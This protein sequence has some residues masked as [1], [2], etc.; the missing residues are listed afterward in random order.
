[1]ERGA[2]KKEETLGVK[3]MVGTEIMIAIPQLIV[4]ELNILN[5]SSKYLRAKA[6][7]KI[8]NK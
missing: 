6:N 5:F 3:Y 2:M 4:L 8:G 7:K 1:M